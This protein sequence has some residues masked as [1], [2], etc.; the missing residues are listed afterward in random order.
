MR[1]SVK[2]EV[3]KTLMSGQV[4][5][6]PKVQEFEEGIAQFLN[7]PAKQVVSV[8]SCTSAIHLAL[9]L[10]KGEVGRCSVITTPMTCAATNIP[11]LHH[12]L[13]IKWCD[14]DNNLNMDLEKARLLLDK[15]TRVLMAVHWG[16]IPLTGL[17][18]LKAFYLEKF[19]YP[20]FIIEDCAH[21]WD[22]SVNEHVGIKNFGCFSCQ[23]IKTLTTGDG[24]LLVCPPDF[25]HRAR[26]KRW[27]GLDRESGATFRSCQDIE[28]V[29]YKFHMNDIAATIGIENL[30]E[31]RQLI[32]KHRINASIYDVLLQKRFQPPKKVG[33]P[34]YWLYTIHVDDRIRFTKYMAENGIEVNPVHTRNDELSIFREYKTSLPNL[35]KLAP[36][37]M[38]IP[39][40]WWLSENQITYI[41]EKINAYV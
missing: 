12:G 40:G 26:L 22:S 25:S 35:D 39:V 29:G 7:T 16:G 17:E 14:V 41:A 11:L 15:N 4:A 21:A 18:E 23:A 27:F 5:Q 36:S 33:N 32:L 1:E 37:M 20:L 30:K 3:A 28:V 10:I 24:G 13:D 31:T 19:G 2:E 9:D 6:G 8:N 34:S 38:C